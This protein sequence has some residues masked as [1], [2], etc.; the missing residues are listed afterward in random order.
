MGDGRIMVTDYLEVVRKA[1]TLH[2]RLISK[3][4]KGGISARMSS[5]LT[6]LRLDKFRR[7]W[8]ND[9][10]GGSNGSDNRTEVLP[11]IEVADGQ[12]GIGSSTED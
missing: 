4:V 2:K 8:S 12:S 3:H 11:V 7:R 10:T 6:G 1:P 5:E 9:P